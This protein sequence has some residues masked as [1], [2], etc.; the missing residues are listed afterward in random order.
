LAHWIRSARGMRLRLP[1][2]FRMGKPVILQGP[3]M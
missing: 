1:L 2:N 3:K